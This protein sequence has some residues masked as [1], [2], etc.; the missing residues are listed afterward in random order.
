MSLALGALGVVFGDIGTSPLYTFRECLRAL[1]VGLHETGILG[2]L[3]LLFWSLLIVVTIK[4]LWFITRADNGGEGGIF[5]LLALSTDKSSPAARITPW[6]LFLLLGAALLYGDGVI[7][8]AVSVLGAMEGLVTVNPELQKLVVPASVVVLIGLFAFQRFG[9]GTIGKIFGPVMLV[10]FGVIGAL[11]A[12]QIA[13]QPEVLRALNPVY[14]LRVLMAGDLRVTALL[15]AVVLAFTGA[16]ALY[17][18]LGHVGRKAIATGWYAVAMPGLLLSYFGQGA[19]ALEHGGDP[20]NP[21]FAIAPEGWMRG[22]LTGLSVLAAIIASQALITGTYSLT[23]QAMQLGFFP[24]LTVRHTNENHEGQIYLPLV[25]SVLAVATIWVTVAFGSSERLASAYGIAVTGTMAVTTVAFGAVLRRRGWSMLRV[26]ALCGLFLVVDGAFFASNLTKIAD[27]GWLPLVMGGLV[28]VIMHSWRT[29]RS[30]VVRRVYANEITEEELGALVRSRNI[31]RVKGS[32]V[33]MAGN[34]RGTPL[35]LLHHLKANRSLHEYVVILSVIT[36]TLPVVPAAERLQ[37]AEIGG[38]V[39]RVVARY[40]YMESPD[41]GGLLEAAREFGVPV[42][43]AA[44]TYYFNHEMVVSGGA[45]S[46]WEWQ[47]RLYGMLSRN[48]RPARD[49]F[50]IPPAQIVELGLPIQL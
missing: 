40:G 5:A 4:Y 19:W 32:A 38:G 20:T 49:Y 9:T 39:W 30:E 47:K 17:A 42:R 24:R 23:R 26:G 7:T 13:Q 27:G 35:V 1:P 33:F 14:A 11:G 37:V 22:G 15:G 2:V 28:L 6:I 44:A 10:W 34:P 18:D 50:R 3:S 29:G 45:S 25:N 41:A 43:P 31:A 46:M 36:E 16:E 12:W 8:P 21:F 48:S